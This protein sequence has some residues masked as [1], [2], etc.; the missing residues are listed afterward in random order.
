MVCGG[1]VPVAYFD[2]TL[3]AARDVTNEE[4]PLDLL[5]RFQRS[6]SA[7]ALTFFFFLYILNTFGFTS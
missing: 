6:T 5:K 1:L 4:S 3:V 7:A 2:C